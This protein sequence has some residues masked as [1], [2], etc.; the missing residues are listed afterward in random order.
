MQKYDCI[1]IG[2][3]PAGLSAAIYLARFKRSVLVIDRRDGRWNTYEKNENYF[4]FPA[5]IPSRKLRQRGLLQAKQFGAE[6]VIADVLRIAKKNDYFEVEIKDDVFFSKT[7][8][9]ATGVHDNFP[10]FPHWRRY[11]GKSMFWC[12]TCDGYKT[13]GKRV[14]IVDKENEGA[15]TALQFLQFTQN[16]TFITNCPP[17]E[18]AI[19]DLYRKRLQEND[20]PFFTGS[21][22][23]VV[24]KKGFIERI[25]LD[26]GE[27]READYL[28]NLQ[29]SNPN[30]SLAAELGMKSDGKGYILVTTEQRTNVPYAYAAG[31]ITKPHS[32]QIITA[33][34]E[35]AMAAQAANYDLYAVWQKA[36]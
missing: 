33:A 23:N 27:E 11:V 4:G 32:H 13:Q 17:S 36:T 14:V 20:I 1:I 19:D 26:T 24:G 21:I 15:I 31:D 35:G 25:A 29:E 7:I 22:T 9:L 6:Y 2:G 12:I 30:N 28:F 18:C 8:I 34:H 16:V 3:G 10:Q 5:G